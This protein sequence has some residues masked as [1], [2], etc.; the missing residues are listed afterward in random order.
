MGADVIPSEF[1]SIWCTAASLDNLLLL[2]LHR[3][4]LLLL[5]PLQLLQALGL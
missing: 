2:L 1:I 3:L 5:L 4:L